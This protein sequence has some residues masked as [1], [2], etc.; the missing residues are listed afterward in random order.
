MEDGTGG[1]SDDFELCSGSGGANT[2]L[3]C[4]SIQEEECTVCVS[5]HAYVVIGVPLIVNNHSAGDSEPGGGS[6]VANA[7]VSACVYGECRLA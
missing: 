1:S 5:F 4:G 6:S 2:N 7:D 3:V